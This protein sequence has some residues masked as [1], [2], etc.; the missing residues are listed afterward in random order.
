MSQ[1]LN[2]LEIGESIKVRG[3]FGKITYLGNGDFKIL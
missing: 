3:P 1:Y 2:D